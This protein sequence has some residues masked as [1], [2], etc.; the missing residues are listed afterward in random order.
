MIKIEFRGIEKLESL[1]RALKDVDKIL[2]SPDIIK[3]LQSTPSKPKLSKGEEEAL[4]KAIADGVLQG[5]KENAEA[6]KQLLEA[7]TKEETDYIDI[8]GDQI[9]KELKDIIIS[10]VEKGN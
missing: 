10:S 5:K 1:T 6:A 8:L 2:K 3:A 4:K 9:I 7:R